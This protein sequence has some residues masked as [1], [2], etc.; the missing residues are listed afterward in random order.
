MVRS[1]YGD[2]GGDTLC[3]TLYA[4]GAGGDALCA[5]LYS[6]GSGGWALFVKVLEVYEVPE[7]IRCVTLYAGE[8]CEG[9]AMFARGVG[10]GSRGDAQCAIL[11]AGGCGGYALS[12][13]VLEV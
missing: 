7:S 5:T 13:E 3:A 1:V 6:G 11:Y 9:C 8:G 12:V 10:S 2:V 4:G